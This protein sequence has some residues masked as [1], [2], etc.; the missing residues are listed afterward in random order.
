MI[1]KSIKE[2]GF[3]NTANIYSISDTSKF[4]GKI[5]WVDEQNLNEKILKAIT[6]LDIGSHTVPIKLGNTFLIILINDKKVED[7]V[8]DQDIIIKKTVQYET[9]RQLSQFSKI[10]YNKVKINS[11]ISEL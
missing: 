7:V 2:V 10:Y 5:G 4:G 3:D 6:N 9:D 11:K 8:I 1:Q